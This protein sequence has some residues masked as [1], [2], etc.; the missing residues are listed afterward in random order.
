MKEINSE[1]KYEIGKRVRQYRLNKGL[2]QEKLAE[3]SGLDQSYIGQME[4]GE[5]NIT[6]STL[7]KITNAMTISVS[8]FTAEIEG[9]VEE[10]KRSTLSEIYQLLLCSDEEVRQAAL[11]IYKV[12]TRV[13]EDRNQR[14]R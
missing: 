8:E 3:L 14:M 4:R 7:M 11:E 2:T 13:S 10:E 1:L 9:T 6:L 5:K 12:L